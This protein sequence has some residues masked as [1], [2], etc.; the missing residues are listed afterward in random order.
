M[1]QQPLYLYFTVF[2][3]FDC[4]TCALYS[5]SS[6][7]LFFYVNQSE[8]YSEVAMSFPM[9]T[10]LWIKCDDGEWWP[11]TVRDV[12]NDLLRHMD[13]GFDTCVEFYHDPGNIYP[14]NASSVDVRPMHVVEAEREEDEK[15]LFR[16]KRTSHAV[17]RAIA[18]NREVTP[19]TAVTQSYCARELTCMSALL[20]SVNADTASQLRQTLQSEGVDLSSRGIRRAARRKPREALKTPSLPGA[21]SISSST[22]DAPIVADAPSGSA[23]GRKSSSRTTT[24]QRRQRKVAKSESVIEAEVAYREPL[25]PAKLDALRLGVFESSDRFV[26]SPVYRYL[27]VLGGVE[28]EGNCVKTTLP[29]PLAFHEEP[30]GGFPPT[31]RV[32]LVPLK[33]LSHGHIDGW[34]QPFEYEGN[35]ISMVLSVNGETV[36]MPSGTSLPSGREKDAVRTAPVVDVTDHV[37]HGELFSLRVSFTGFIDDAKLW[38][39]IIVAVHVEHMDMDVLVNQIMSSNLVPAR[40]DRDDVVGVQ[41]RVVCPLTSLPLVIPVRGVDCEHM[42][43]VELRSLLIHCIRTNVWNCPLC[44]APTTPGT[45]TVNRRLKEWLE[46]HCSWVGEVDF[47]METPQGTPLH[48]VWRKKNSATVTAVFAVE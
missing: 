29:S 11:A 7:S 13:C 23:L 46:A 32:L 17:R 9:G 26:L 22:E 24:S 31:Q 45:I 15:P 40:A 21:P 41:V 14:I 38:E 18:A 20:D 44:W 12:G 8:V 35:Q 33:N 43:C 34:M 2:S 28:V 30:S 48:V 25:D 3:H 37:M 19:S 47:I 5:V 27:D 39:G 4:A 6:L 36:A 16:V 10:L 1:S 42:Q